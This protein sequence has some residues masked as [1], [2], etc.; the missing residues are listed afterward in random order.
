M[1]Q[2][3]IFSS[4][5]LTRLFIRHLETAFQEDGL[6]IQA[7]H[8]LI[9][10]LLSEQGEQNQ[11][12][13]AKDTIRGKTFITRAVV[14]LEKKQ[15]LKRVSDS[16]DKRAKIVSLTNKGEVFYSRILDIYQRIEKETLK[17]IPKKDQKEA[18]KIIRQCMENLMD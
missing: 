2:E 9:L 6:S 14:S 8:F 3:L 5:L 10:K 17:S 12:N 11:V 16:V 1:K 13:L 18:L 7:E 15:L 4:Y